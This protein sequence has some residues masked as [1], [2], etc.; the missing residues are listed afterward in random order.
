M[1]KSVFLTRKIPDIAIKILEAKG[2]S[3]DVNQADKILSKDELISVLKTKPYDAVL[4]LLT[5]VVDKDIFDTAPSVKIF[6]NYASGF[7][8]IDIN[9]AKNRN[10]VI[11]NSPAPV[12]SNAVAEHT[13]SLLMA[14]ARK[15]VDADQFVRDG[16]YTGWEAMNFIGSGLSGK[17]LAIIGAGRIGSMVAK[18]AKG[19][20]LEIIYLNENK[21]DA[22]EKETGAIFYSSLEEIL[23]KAD[24]VS[25]HVP[26]LP[27]TKHLINEKNISLMRKNAFLI[28]TSRG[29]VVDELALE[30]ALKGGLVAGAGLDVFEFEPKVTPGLLNLPNV[31]FTPHIASAT[32]EARNQMAE[33]SAENIVDFFEGKEVINKVNK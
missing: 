21:N 14:L 7:D 5:D 11:A 6:S 32:V 3:V 18:M 13:I 26:L 9:E 23:P 17:T 16:K 8:N 30:R 15:V 33:I 27:S 19:L 4:C 1:T 24:F 20:G 12:T 2:F 28:N 22:F 31:I 29:P 10:I 25:L